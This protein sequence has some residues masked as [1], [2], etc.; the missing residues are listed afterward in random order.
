MSC[1]FLFPGRVAQR[2]ERPLTLKC[3]DLGEMDYLPWNQVH[4]RLS[5]EEGELFLVGQGKPV[6][7]LVPGVEAGVSVGELWILQDLW[8]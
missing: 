4:S 5:P 7:R 3:S 8:Q 1:R 2:L 6:D